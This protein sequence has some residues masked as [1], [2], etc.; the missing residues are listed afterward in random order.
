MRK[1]LLPLAAAAALAGAASAFAAQTSD[2]FQARINIVTSC[3]VTA[4]D[5]DFGNVGVI[6][7]G[8]SATASVDVNCSAGTVYSLSFDPALPPAP[9]VAAYTSAM[10]NGAEDVAYSAALSGVGGVGPGSFTITGVLPAQVTPPAALYV[11]NKVVY[12]NY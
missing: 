8:E 7:G 12:L 4:G 2:N 3:I 6:V 9:P 5:L 10:V 1:F 11:D